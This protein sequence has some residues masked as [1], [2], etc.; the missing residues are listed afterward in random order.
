MEG[1]MPSPERDPLLFVKHNPAIHP[2]EFLSHTRVIQGHYE[3]RK[4]VLVMSPAK[5]C[6]VQGPEMSNKGRIEA[7]LGHENLTFDVPSELGQS[8]EGRL[9]SSLVYYSGPHPSH[10]PY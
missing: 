1:L 6:V 3:R 7:A 5:I 2:I 10:T 4:D 9:K 8:Q